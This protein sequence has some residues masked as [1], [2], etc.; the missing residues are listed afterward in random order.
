M[1]EKRSG[2]CEYCGHIR[3][4]NDLFNGACVPCVLWAEDQIN[5]LTR[6]VARLKVA[7]GEAMLVVESQDASIARLQAELEK[8]KAPLTEEQEYK[9][10]ADLGASPFHWR[11][12]DAAI[13]AAREGGGK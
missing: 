11:Q 2:E 1:N 6:E 4:T 3:Y 10:T 8:F 7:E 12:R 9:L 5:A 13:R